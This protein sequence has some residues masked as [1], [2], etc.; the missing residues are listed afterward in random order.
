M[1]TKAQESLTTRNNRNIAV[2]AEQADKGKWDKMTRK[3]DEGRD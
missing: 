1:C 3:R 2:E